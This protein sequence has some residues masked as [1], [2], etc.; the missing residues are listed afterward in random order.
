MFSS[1]YGVGGAVGCE[2]CSCMRGGSVVGFLVFVG[3][4]GVDSG[5]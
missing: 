5:V 4:G 3:V 1:S 2:C